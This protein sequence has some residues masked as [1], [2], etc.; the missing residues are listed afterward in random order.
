LGLSL[1]FDVVLEY[2][3][4]WDLPMGLFPVAVVMLGIGIVSFARFLRDYPLP[5]GGVYDGS[6]G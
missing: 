3:T 4:G 2:T 6:N 1:P 5:E